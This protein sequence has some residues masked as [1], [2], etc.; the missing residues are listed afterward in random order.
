MPVTE[1]RKDGKK[2]H[3]WG[4]SGVCFIGKDSKEKAAAVGRAIHARQNQSLFELSEKTPNRVQVAKVGSFNHEVY[5]KFGFTLADLESM[6]DNFANNARRQEIEGKPVLPFDYSH[7]EGEEAAGWIVNLEIGQDKKGVAALF[8]DVDW[9]DKAKKKIKGK[10]F[11]FVSPSIARGYKDAETGEKFN[12]VLKGAA[13]T[14]I[15]FLRDMEAVHALSEDRRAA[16]ES[17]KA[18]GDTD[19]N[20]QLG[21]NMPELIEKYQAMSP[22]DKEKFLAEC[23]LMPKDKKLSE[24]LEQV[25]GDLQS[26]EKA[27]KLAEGER[28]ELKAKYVDSDEKSESL[29]LAESKIGDLEKEVLKLTQA[30]E[31]DKKEA[32]F[33]V[34][35]SE[36]KACPAQKDAFMKGDVVEFAKN[37]QEVKLNE[38][39]GNAKGDEGGDAQTKVLK[40]AEEK[41]NENDGMSYGDAVSIVLSENPELN[42]KYEEGE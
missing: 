38:I 34:M 13:L 31:T 7:A 1:C 9:T 14:N 2:G 12:I 33:S 35:L 41:M 27:L 30:R 42:R 40:L 29:K 4:E 25:K 5:G 20:I 37:A 10:E 28:D 15:P 39:G 19:S 18:S 16:F 23:G 11:R 26:K 8:A 22:E 32:E 17:L 36:G 3:K 6:R 21:E 24:E